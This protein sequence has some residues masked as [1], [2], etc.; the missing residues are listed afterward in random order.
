[1][2]EEIKNIL[3]HI[4]CAPCTAYSFEKLVND[5]Y[6]VTGF[7]YNPNIHP[8]KEHDRRLHELKIFF[9]KENYKLIIKKDHFTVWFEATEGFNQ[10]KEGGKRCEVCFKLRLEATALLAKQEGFDGFT[11]VLTI[12]PHK[13]SEVIN[14]IGRDIEEKVGINFIEEN[15][16]KQDGVKKSLELSAKHGFY[17]QNYCGCVYSQKNII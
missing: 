14:Q 6:N 9:E 5:G 13:N 12:S 7:F 2:Q 1:M 17:R 11:T 10:E 8:T 16:K 3:V 4:C 15:L